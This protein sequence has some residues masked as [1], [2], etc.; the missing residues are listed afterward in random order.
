LIPLFGYL[1][2][3]A[4]VCRGS[5][6]TSPRRR[7]FASK[8]VARGGAGPG[9]SRRLSPKD[10]PGS[11]L[12]KA[13]DGAGAGTQ[14]SRLVF[15]FFFRGYLVAMVSWLA[16]RGWPAWNAGRDLTTAR[17]KGSRC[18]ELTVPVSDRRPRDSCTGSGAGAERWR[19]G[20]GPAAAAGAGPGGAPGSG[21]LCPAPAAPR[22]ALAHV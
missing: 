10:G 15:S 9:R 19:A 18:W 14:H 17:R 2:T 11:S 22:E 16:G 21:V 8:V 3:V 4:R 13:G 20:R 1:R 6:L 5:P 7:I 12:Q